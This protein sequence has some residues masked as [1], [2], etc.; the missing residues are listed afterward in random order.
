MHILYNPTN[1]ELNLV[2]N[3][4][5]YGFVCFPPILYK[6]DYGVRIGR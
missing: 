1:F 3:L 2:Q 6:L 4:L 5:D